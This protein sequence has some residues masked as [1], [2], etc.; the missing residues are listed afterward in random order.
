[1]AEYVEIDF[2]D[3]ETK[4]SG[5]AICLRYEWGAQTFIHVVDGGFLDTGEKVVSQIR[6]F[7][8]N[9][10]R[11]HHVVATHPDGDHAAGLRKVLEEFDVGTLWMLR[12]WEYAAQ[13]IHRFPTYTSVDALRS[14]LKA[15]YPNLAALETIAAARGITIAEPFQGRVIGAFQVL[16]PTKSRY[17]D[18]IVDSERTPEAA[19]EPKGVGETVAQVFEKIAAKVTHY[20]KAL[21]GTET[22]P[23][24]ETSAENEMSVVQFA[25]IDGINIVLTA[26]TGR[27]GLAEAADYAPQAGLTL[28]GVDMFQA[29]HHGSRRNVSS[30]LLD[31]WLGQKL[32]AALPA[33]QKRFD[34]IISSAK[35]DEDH[36]RKSV[37]RAMIHRGGKVATTEGKTVRYSTDNAPSRAGWLTTPAEPYPDE[38]ET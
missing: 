34:V 19:E 38:E 28:P 10:P 3:V 9:P 25:R 2:L 5:D 21:W 16:A 14:R 32:P 22:F 11:I 4:S 37:V 15:V 35:E 18:C 24:E 23:P 27:K 36:P 33:G 8:G 20:V 6:Q 29:P 13:L 26:D 17:L 1:M 7:Y 31:R 12:P 30:E